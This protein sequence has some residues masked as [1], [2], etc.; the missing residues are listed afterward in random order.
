M[1]IS[2]FKVLTVL[3][4]QYYYHILSEVAQ[5]R[6][7]TPEESF[8]Q[9]Q[10]AFC[11]FIE[12]LSTRQTQQVFM[13]WFAKVNYICQIYDLTPSQQKQ[14]QQLRR[15][16]LRGIVKAY[17]NELPRQLPIAV[18]FLTELIAH[19]SEEA[20]P[21]TLWHFGRQLPPEAT[22]FDQQQPEQQIAYLQLI[23][24]EKSPIQKNKFGQAE[25]TITA[26]SDAY[27]LLQIRLSDTRYSDKATH[28]LTENCKYLRAQQPIALTHLALEG[29]KLATSTDETLLIAFPDYLVDASAIAKCF[30]NAENAVYPYLLDKLSFFQGN[31]FTFTGNLI[32]QILDLWVKNPEVS[33]E[34]TFQQALRLHKAEAVLYDAETLEQIATMLRPQFAHIQQALRPYLGQVLLTEPSF[35][36]PQFGLQGRLDLMVLYPQQPQRRDIIELKS[37]RSFPEAHAGRVARQQDLVQVACYNLMLGAVFPDRQGVSSILYAADGLQPLRDCGRLN[38]EMQK[39]MQVRNRLLSLDLE[40]SKA[41]TKVF[42]G[43]F[44][45]LARQKGGFW[46]QGLAFQ[47][48]WQAAQ[49]VEI[50]YFVAFFAFLQRELLI[51]KTGG[52][53]YQEASEG[54]ASLWKLNPDDKKAQFALLSE[55]VFTDWNAD[56]SEITLQRPPEAFISAFRE[57]DLVVLYPMEADQSFR[58][59]N[60]PLLKGTL[61]QLTNT[62]IVVKLWTQSWDKTYFEQHAL[63]AIEPSFLENSYRYLFASLAAFLAA[64][65]Y[66]KQL[67]LGQQPPQFDSDFQ[68]PRQTYDLDEHQAQLIGKALSAQ[69]YF[70]VQGP[71]GTGKTSKMLRTMV[72]YLYHH[73]AETVV[74]LAFTNRATDEICAQVN[75]IC[76][77]HYIRFGQ[78]EASHPYYEATFSAVTDATTLR[79]KIARTRIFVS[80]VASYFSHQHFIAQKDVVIVDEA[81]QLLEPHLCGILPAFKRFIL[82]GDEKQLPAVVQQP[83]ASS[84]ATHDSLKALGIHNLSI[85]FFERLL[86]NAQQKQW[87]QA[88]QMLE[89]QFRTHQTIAN[90][91]GRL[92]YKTLKIGAPRQQEPWQWFAQPSEAQPPVSMPSW[93]ASSRL[94]FRATTTHDASLKTNQDE[95]QAVV[96]IIRQLQTLYVQHGKVL[97]THSIGVITPFRAQM[98][99]IYRLLDDDLRVLITVDTVERFQGSERDIIIY[100]LAANYPAQMK[101][102]Q[103]LNPEATVDRK[104]NVALSRSR[105]QFILLGNRQVLAEGIYYKALLEYIEKLPSTSAQ[106]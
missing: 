14:V 85:S 9:L 78:V 79:Q 80:T 93:L 37:A 46:D 19:F 94:L 77:E 2:A 87:H 33:F 23:F 29:D 25:I 3:D 47:K 15:L 53:F 27:G 98:A 101:F 18:A 59:T 32:N 84:Q 106:Q 24:L 16:L 73:T 6:H 88:F 42:E 13:G 38:F 34:D 61:L 28:Q 7:P 21:D 91:Y 26:E 20:P 10:A 12:T 69:D 44:H 62:Q 86:R 56:R 36:A 89:T 52:V 43:L 58:P 99:E 96:Q 100:S 67:L 30:E 68:W 22:L 76:P 57:G 31:F 104:L 72:H 5:G 63:W 102:L 49:P 45:F 65:A 39:A 17:A 81:S 90:F 54:F 74:L 103:A 95:A 60:H 50:D 40:L 70:L 8:R 64:P 48:H 11:S 97:H 35:L 51:A 105:E 1:S 92:F 75:A 83:A 55:L 66:K 71:P 41:N 4:S 82:I